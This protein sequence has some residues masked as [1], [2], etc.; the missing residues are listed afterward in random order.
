MFFRI[1]SICLYSLP[2]LHVLG[3]HGA[4]M[5]QSIHFGCNNA[6]P[7]MHQCMY[8]A[9]HP[10]SPHP[11]NC[12]FSRIVTLSGCG[13]QFAWQ[14]PFT[15]LHLPFMMFMFHIFSLCFCV[16]SWGREEGILSLFAGLTASL[17]SQAIEE[18][19]YG[20][21]FVSKVLFQFQEF[22]EPQ[23]SAQL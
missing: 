19:G 12:F 22:Q 23:N 9:C 10:I 14:N 15:C 11:Q 21:L 6:C 8:P 20:E 1:T 13:L 5:L 4:A 3:I 16:P 7:C 17:I 2:W 18:V